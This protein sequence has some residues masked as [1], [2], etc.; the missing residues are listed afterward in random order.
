[1]EWERASKYSQSCGPWRLGASRVQ[2]KLIYGLWRGSELIGYYH[3]P[4][5]AKKAAK[6]R[7]K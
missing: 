3:D 1:M 5:A 6:E 7:A 2:G 4:K